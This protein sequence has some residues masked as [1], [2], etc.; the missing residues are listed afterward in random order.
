MAKLS[1]TTAGFENKIM[2]LKLGP[3]RIGRSP[4]CD[5]TVAHPTVSN[6]HCE[7]VL[8]EDG[9]LIRD[10]ESTNGTFVNG[11]SV[12]EATLGPGEVLRLG[13]VELLVES[14]DVSVAIPQF[15]DAELPAPPVVC[16]DGSI[17][18][19]RHEH[20]R[21]THKCKHCH[22]VMCPA[23]IHRLQRKGSTRILLLCPVCSHPVGLIGGARVVKK[24]SLL[25]RVGET[26]KLKITRAIRLVSD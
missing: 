14:T 1:I 15:N 17:V 22:E 24:K 11:S 23:C 5:F 13:D 18:C 10:L 16:S 3:N 25:V 20:A 12:R 2:E 9:I 6:I 7:L 19:P 26:V 4:D 21:A 8:R